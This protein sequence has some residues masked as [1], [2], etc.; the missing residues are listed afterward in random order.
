[1]QLI[2]LGHVC[3]RVAG[4]WRTAY[5]VGILPILYMLYYRIFRLR[6]SAVWKKAHANQPRHMGLLFKHYWPRILAT[7]GAWFL[8]D[9]SFY[10]NKVFQSTFIKVLSPSGSGEHSFFCLTSPHMVLIL[11]F[12]VLPLEDCYT[13][14]VIIHSAAEAFMHC[15]LSGLCKSCHAA[16]LISHSHDTLLAT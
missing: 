5:G 9:F 8:W 2:F 7:A 12:T 11:V 3:C 15:C 14:S 6:E 13:S 16:E 10:G 1:M 4:V